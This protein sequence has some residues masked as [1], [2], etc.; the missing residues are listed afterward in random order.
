MAG[1]DDEM[2]LLARPTMVRWFSPTLL[3]NAAV[4]AAVSPVF[5]TFADARSVQANVD[6]FSDV[7]LE[8]V[9]GRYDFSSPQTVGDVVADAEGAVWVD[10]LA[11]TGDGF[12]STYAMASLVAAPQLSVSRSGGKERYD[13]PAG[14]LFILGGDQVYPYPSREE[15]RDRFETPFAMAFSDLSLKRIT[16]VIPG[17]HD[18]YDGLNSFDYLFCQARYGN[19]SGHLGSL[20][21]RQHR[22]YFSIRLANNWWIWGADIQ[23]SA[24][25]DAG[26]ARYFQAVAAQMT[27]WRPGEP[28]HKVI[29][30]SAAPGWQYEGIEGDTANSNIRF[31]ADI[32]E[33]AGGKVCAV[34]SGDA[35]HYS[36]YYS[37]VLGLNLITA[38]GGGAF[39]HPTHQLYN[40]IKYDWQGDR[41][42]AFDLGC[43]EPLPGSGGKPEA[44][45]F[46]T[47]LQSFGLTWGNLFFPVWNP[48]FATLLGTFYWLMTWMYSQ[49]PVINRANCTID[50][51][52]ETRPLVEDI[53]V[54]NWQTCGIQGKTAAAKLQ[55]V[56]G[57]SVSAGIYQFLLGIFGLLLLVTLVGYADARRRWKKVL[58]GSMHW[59]AHLIAM[60]GLYWLVNHYGYWTY[61]GDGTRRLFEPLLGASAGLLQTVAY[62][63]QMIFFGGFV[64]G[65][66]WGGYLFLCCAFGRRH[67]NDAFSALRIPDFKN[68]LRMK[69]EP[70]RL[71]IY[72]IGLVRAPTRIE[73]RQAKG[74]P[75]GKLEPRIP[76]APILID[77]PIV[78]DAKAVRRSPRSP[79][80]RTGTA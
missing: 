62:M 43:R 60:V 19:K 57:I 6:G 12:D 41:A 20:E 34:L 39:L 51:R 24:H 71:T 25:L 68:F 49:T 54:S 72:P 52:I 16:F 7:E 47:K 29:L 32:V 42:H 30:C 75:E 37:K 31:V 58:I 67:W 46:P 78:I 22:S 63:L 8:A 64:A 50:G 76:L 9:A 74:G 69:I 26:Q 4:R 2:S 3:A 18:W 79:A 17:N 44:A 28:E 53:L 14:K 13:L 61:F 77:G 27:S 70:E 21:F 5:G 56:I 15:Y 10:Y 11:D 65:F 45:V 23:F 1:T 55:D 40:D 48:T 35:H 66:V 33:K 36:R 80:V 59:L 73:W 38:G